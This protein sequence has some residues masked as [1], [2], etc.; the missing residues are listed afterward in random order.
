MRTHRVVVEVDPS[1]ASAS[2][3][4]WC[5]DHSDS[6]DEVIAVASLSNFQE[7]VL[8]IPP[9][10]LDTVRRDIR[11]VLDHQRTAP[12]RARGVRY[13]TRLEEGVPWRAVLDVA[14]AEHADAVVVGHR[15]HTHGLGSREVQ[16]LVDHST[17]P[18]IVVPYRSPEGT[19]GVDGAPAEQSNR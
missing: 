10:D 15:G 9:A 11:Y 17:V 19:D 8:S 4:Q 5:A 14:D 7:L 18:V 2:A 12:L 3:V 13:H 6:D 1:P 16:R